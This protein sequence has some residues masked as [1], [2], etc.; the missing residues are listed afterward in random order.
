MIKLL[1]YLQHLY[2]LV[3]SKFISNNTKDVVQYKQSFVYLLLLDY[4]NVK[5]QLE[6]ASFMNYAA[7]VFMLSLLC[8]TSFISVI[9]YFTAY[10]MVS[11]YDLDEKLKS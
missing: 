4:F 10:Y 1:I 11:K 8:L 9:L 6:M 2:N 5:I 7:G 3:L